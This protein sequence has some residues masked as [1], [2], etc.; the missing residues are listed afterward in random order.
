MRSA[1]EP[2][3][4]P[5]LFGGGYGLYRIQRSSFVL[6]LLV[7]TLGLALLLTSSRYLVEHHHEI[8]QQVI[9]VVTDVSPYILP[10]S[11]SKAGG[12]GGG[13]ARLSGSFGWLPS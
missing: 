10:P 1:K 11:A 5:T 9:G 6:S 2:V 4:L 7:H 13:V 12:G 8:R 3:I